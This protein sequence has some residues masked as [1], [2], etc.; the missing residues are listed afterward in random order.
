[1]RPYEGV[2]RSFLTNNLKTILQCHNLPHMHSRFFVV[3]SI[4]VDVEVEEVITL[5]TNDIRTPAI[6][7]RGSFE[8]SILGVSRA[9]D[10]P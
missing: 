9:G 6:P 8:V 5:R 4:V 7:W 10:G 3:L 2:G 1:M